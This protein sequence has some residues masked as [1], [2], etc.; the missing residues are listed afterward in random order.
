MDDC[1]SPNCVLLNNESMLPTLSAASARSRKASGSLNDSTR[2][3]LS[4]NRLSS[5]DPT[6]PV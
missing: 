2:P 4:S 1:S 5:V 6:W 3:V